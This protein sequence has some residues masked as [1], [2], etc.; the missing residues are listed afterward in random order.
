MSNR[1]LPC[2]GKFPNFLID[3]YW[4]NSSCDIADNTEVKNFIASVYC[5][6]LSACFLSCNFLLNFPSLFFNLKSFNNSAL[7]INI[8]F[9]LLFIPS[10]KL[11]LGTNLARSFL[12]SLK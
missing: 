6:S 9:C 5:L 11:Y 10:G 1:S 4:F 8:V 12:V 7:Y 3:S 2:K